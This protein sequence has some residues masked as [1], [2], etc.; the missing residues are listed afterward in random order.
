VPCAPFACACYGCASL[1]LWMC[2]PFSLHK[3]L[4]PQPS[5]CAH[6]ISNVPLFTKLG[7]PPYHGCTLLQT[8]LHPQAL[9]HTC[10]PQVCP[11]KLENGFLKQCAPPLQRCASLL[12]SKPSLP[13]LLFSQLSQ[14]KNEP[15][16]YPFPSFSLSSAKP[17]RPMA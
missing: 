12:L 6:T 15:H 5:K 7:T 14:V 1:Q 10:I 11:H 8:S 16:A 13:L 4:R 17:K 2:P 9:N 3:L